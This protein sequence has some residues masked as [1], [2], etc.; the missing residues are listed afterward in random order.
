MRSG[1]RGNIVQGFD[2]YRAGRGIAVLLAVVAVEG[3]GMAGETDFRIMLLQLG[4]SQDN[5]IIG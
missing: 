3:K 2:F 1:F 4:H 5:R